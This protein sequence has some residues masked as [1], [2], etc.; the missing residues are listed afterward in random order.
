MKA[1]DRDRAARILRLR[2]DARRARMLLRQVTDADDLQLYRQLADDWDRE[3]DLL[4]NPGTTQS[5]D[6]RSP[7]KSR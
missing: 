2:T 4:E 3:A 5:I 7:A 6:G 1:R